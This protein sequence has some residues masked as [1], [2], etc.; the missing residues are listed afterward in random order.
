M[1]YLPLL[2]ITNNPPNYMSV[3][4]VWPVR[5]LHI[6]PI[7]FFNEKTQGKKP[8]TKND[9]NKENKTTAGRTNNN[10]YAQPSFKI[11]CSTKLGHTPFQTCVTPESLAALASSWATLLPLLFKCWKEHQEK[12]EEMSFMFCTMWPNSPP[13]T[14]SL[15]A[16]IIERASNSTIAWEILNS[17]A[18]NTPYCNA[19]ASVTSAENVDG[20]NL[21]EDAIRQPRQSQIATPV[22]E[23]L[24]SEAVPSVLIYIY[25]KA[26]A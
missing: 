21:L 11:I 9:Y 1:L 17:K 20:S 8:T 6:T 14:P 2:Q 13:K 12:E 18:S 4:Q 3:H 7:F 15:I 5:R 24:P 22:Q 26:E 23:G 10:S 16:W 19:K 25:L